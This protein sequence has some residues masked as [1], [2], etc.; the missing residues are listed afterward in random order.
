[1]LKDLGVG[2]CQADKRIIVM[3]NGLDWAGGPAVLVKSDLSDLLKV[4]DLLNMG[5]L[6]EEEKFDG[7]LAHETIYLCYSSGSWGVTFVEF[8]IYFLT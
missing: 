5:H 3:A 8:E 7:Q 1:M 2:A 4:A 6:E